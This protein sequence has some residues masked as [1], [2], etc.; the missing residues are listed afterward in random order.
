MAI[1]QRITL[2]SLDNTLGFAT[3]PRVVSIPE[4]GG[5]GTKRRDLALAKQRFS[6]IKR[7][8]MGNGTTRN[9]FYDLRARGPR[10]SRPSAGTGRIRCPGSGLPRAGLI[11]LQLARD[12]N[13]FPIL[14]LEIAVVA[15]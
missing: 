4:K 2:R 7:Q 11:T 1:T 15:R 9:G 3:Y 14:L 8:A 10:P 13:Q 6:R 5:Q 12:T